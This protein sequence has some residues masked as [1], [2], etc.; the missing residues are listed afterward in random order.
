MRQW[1]WIVF[2]IIFTTAA[3]A[4]ILDFTPKAFDQAQKAGERVVLMIHAPW[5]GHCLIIRQ[6][7]N[8]LQQKKAFKN[9]LFLQLPLNIAADDKRLKYKQNVDTTYVQPYLNTHPSAHCNLKQR[10]TLVVIEHNKVLACEA[11]QTQKEAL[12]ALFLMETP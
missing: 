9:I 2:C 1:I 10:S 6:H 8:A 3:N 5:C 12:S 7:I 4:A 11:F